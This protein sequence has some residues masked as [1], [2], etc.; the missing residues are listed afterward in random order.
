MRDLQWSRDIPLLVV[1]TSAL[2]QPSVLQEVR[3]E[4]PAPL[5]HPLLCCSPAWE[6]TESWDTCGPALL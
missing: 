3:R 4:G 2:S 6:G 1:G 5:L